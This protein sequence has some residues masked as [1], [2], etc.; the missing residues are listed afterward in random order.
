M[1]I[2]DSMASMFAHSDFAVSFKELLDECGSKRSEYHVDG[3]HLNTRG[4]I[5][6]AAIL[7]S[8]VKEHAFEAVVGDSCLCAMEKGAEYV[9]GTWMDYDGT[10]LQPFIS[11]P[12]FPAAGKAFTSRDGGFYDVVTKAYYATEPHPKVI[13]LLCAGN[14]IWEG[15]CAD[16]VAGHMIWLQEHW[17]TWGVTLVYIDVVPDRFRVV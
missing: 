9:G 10:V 4:L 14:D 6:A 8:V 13:G 7:E 1:A 5:H 17:A 2:Y 11:V 12:C 3:L 16:A 15:N